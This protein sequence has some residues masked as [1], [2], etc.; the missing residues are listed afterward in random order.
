[1]PNICMNDEFEVVW[2]LFD[3]DVKI[4]CTKLYCYSVVFRVQA[5]RII[6]TTYISLYGRYL[7]RPWSWWVYDVRTR[8]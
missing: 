7:K 4:V 6:P 2:G 5:I 8:F 3:N 1:M